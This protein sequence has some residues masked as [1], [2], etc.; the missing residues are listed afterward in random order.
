MKLMYITNR[1]DVAAIAENAGVDRIFVDMEYIGKELRQAGMDTVKSHHTVEDIRRIRARISKAELLVRCNPIH[2]A[3]TEYTSSRE[4]ID[5]IV[6]AGADI[7]MLPYF[8]TVEEVQTFLTLV[9]GRT[10]TM[11]L[12]ET[13]EAV[14]VIDR[15]MALPGIDELFVGLNDLSLSYGK[16][17]MFSLLTDGTV[18]KLC[19]KFREAGYVYG[20]GGVASIGKGLLPGEYVIREHYRLGSSGA[21]LSR[22]FC[23]IFKIDDMEK[24]RDLFDN[25]LRQI[26]QLE[27]ECCCQDAEYF[28]KNRQEACRIV[29]Q[30]EGK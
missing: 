10:K 30:I 17:F 16:S 8:K 29:A 11:L 18:E 9:A 13:K 1:P 3:T 4:E 12:V 26:R 5:A 2:E 20:F 19:R 6:Q 25:G 7:I 24:V 22:S 28:Q 23:D 14:E 27:A 15:I 21:I